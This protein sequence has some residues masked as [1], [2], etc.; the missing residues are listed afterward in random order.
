MKFDRETLTV[1]GVRIVMLT[2]GSGPPLLYMHG[3]GTWHGFDFAL[4]WAAHHRVMIPFHPGWG[5]SDDCADMTTIHDY[6]MHYLEL[7]DQLQ[8]PEVDLV[9]FSMGG[10]MAATFTSEHRRRVRKLVLVAPAG[11]EV[12]GYPLTDFSKI[13]P[14]DIL[15]YI[16]ENVALIAQ[17][18]PTDPS[19]AWQAERE[20][21]GGHF[22]TLLQNGLSDPKFTRWLHRLT[23][24]S[25]L[26][27]GEKDRTTPVQQANA[28]LK[29]AP[30]LQLMRVAGAG[31]LVLDEKPEV[32]TAIG[33]FLKS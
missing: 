31:H 5:E 27:W 10:R 9:G 4:P 24:P 28:W 22:F 30:K 8:L 17:R 23:I 6:V 26:V 21:E 3:A 18:A 12:P 29:F 13:A 15:G 32:V 20:R 7:I 14:Q 2:A 25:L 33:D 16:T 11:L 19:A 1:N